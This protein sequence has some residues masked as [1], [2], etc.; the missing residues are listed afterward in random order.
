MTMC[1]SAKRTISTASASLFFDDKSFESFTPNRV[2]IGILSSLI[3]TPAMTKGPITQPRPASSTPATN[4]CKLPLKNGLEIVS[5]KTLEKRGSSIEL[6]SISVS[7]L[8]VSVGFLVKEDLY[9]LLRV[10]STVNEV[11]Q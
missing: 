5:Y 2:R 1:F 3:R 6:V 11:G 10:G 8:R 7:F 9:V 4:T